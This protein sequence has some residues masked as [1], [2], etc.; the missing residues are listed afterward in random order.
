MCV[1]VCECVCVCVHVCCPVSAVLGLGGNRRALGVRAGPHPP[2]PNRCLPQAGSHILAAAGHCVAT[3]PRSSA[4]M[5][6][7][8][9]KRRRR[10]PPVAQ[11]LRLL[12]AVCCE[13]H[14]AFTTRRPNHVPQQLAAGG[15]QPCTQG[16]KGGVCVFVCLCVCVC[17]C[18]CV[19]G[20]GGG[21][22][23][24]GQ[25]GGSAAKG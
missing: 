11:R 18:V 25:A 23:A 16:T 2:L 4:R 10:A 13:D 15:V 9:N 6:K 17:V 5:R 24:R 21:A 14:G 12:H 7:R 20:G 1:S 19:W 8:S 22:R 3:P